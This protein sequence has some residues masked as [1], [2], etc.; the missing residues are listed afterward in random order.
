MHTPEI[1]E[2]RMDES[3]EISG[4]SDG[5]KQ[6]VLGWVWQ[7]RLLPAFWTVGAVF[8]ILLNVIL[9]GVLA[10][11][12]KQLFA[13]KNTLQEDY[14]GGLQAS[15]VMLDE[16]VIETNIAV[17]EVIPMKFDLPINQASV[18][19]L[20][21]EIKVEGARVVY[22]KAGINLIDTSMD[23][24]LPAGTRLPVTLDLVIPVETTLP[25]KLDVP[26]VIALK[27]TGLH[28][29]LVSLQEVLSGLSNLLGQ[30]PGS[31]GELGCLISLPGCE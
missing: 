14:V 8:S 16:A 7:G 18:V 6:P 5:E 27:D 21:R 24:I 3:Q 15:F 13:L 1:E 19:T 23:I 10:A 30:L 11:A 28:A 4:E 31:W 29:P 20:D 2:N 17:E 22:T 12:G 26:V 25:V 9:I